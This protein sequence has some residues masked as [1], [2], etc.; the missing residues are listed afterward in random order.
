M[1]ELRFI[2]MYMTKTKN[3]KFIC[4]LHK[5]K[6]EA[7]QYVKVPDDTEC[8]LCTK[9]EMITDSGI[10]AYRGWNLNGIQ[11]TSLIAKTVWEPRKRQELKGSLGFHAIKLFRPVYKPIYPDLSN[12]ILSNLSDEEMLNLRIEVTTE[13]DIPTSILNTEVIY[14]NPMVIGSVYLWGEYTEHV[15]GYRAEFAYPKHL[16]IIEKRYGEDKQ[17]LPELCEKI[18]ELYGIP[19]E[20][21]YGREE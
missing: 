3:G 14:Y 2:K 13:I 17:Y 20:I 5:G 11:L 18:S 16:W 10:V 7:R 15:Y 9:H 1:D 19:V 12:L 8:S 6:G 21:Y 4:Q